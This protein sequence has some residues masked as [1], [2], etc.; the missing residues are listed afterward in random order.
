MAVAWAIPRILKRPISIEAGENLNGSAGSRRLEVRA[1]LLV[2][3]TIRHRKLRH[4]Q[5]LARRAVFRH[6]KLFRLL[7]VPV[8]SIAAAIQRHIDAV[9]QIVF[10]ERFE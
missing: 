1:A 3:R 4:W 9:D 2:F 6:L 8:G 10:I 7:L 5:W